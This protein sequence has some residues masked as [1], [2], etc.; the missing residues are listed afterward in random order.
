MND[1]PREIRKNENRSLTEIGETASLLSKE[2]LKSLLYLVAGK[3]DSNVKLFWRIIC[4]EPEDISELNER[5]QEKLMQHNTK[6]AVASV[7]VMYKNGRAT[8]FGT[9]P[10]FE[11]YNWH[12]THVVEKASVKWDFI[13]QLPHYAIPQ[14]HT[15]TV[16]LL[17]SFSPL[18]MLQAIFSKNPDQISEVEMETAPILCR[19]DFISH[20][21]SDE[22]INIVEEWVKSRSVAE[23]IT[24][25]KTFLKLRKRTIARFVHYSLPFLFGLLSASILHAKFAEFT[26][27]TLVPISIFKYSLYWLLGTGV[28]ISAISLMGKYLGKTIYKT[29]DNYGIHTMFCFTNGDKNAKKENETKNT[30][31]IRK[32]WFNIVV[33]IVINLTC[34]FIA[35]LLFVG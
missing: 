22:L 5:I 12:T 13:I 26:P 21:L 8:Q 2:G 16:T 18:H 10:E 11:D 29:I 19:V 15:L 4:I 32:F 17:G 25:P 6:A 34:A 30:A 7:D 31:L 9:W 28:G 33:S 35:Y 14:R 27:N 20:L 1:K 23:F 3:Q 24:K